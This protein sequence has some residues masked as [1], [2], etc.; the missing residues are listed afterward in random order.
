MVLRFLDRLKQIPSGDVDSSV[1][2]DVECLIVRSAQYECFAKEIEDLSKGKHLTSS[3]SLYRLDPFLDKVG[4]LRLEGRFENS[5]EPC[6]IKH[7]I[8][9]PKKSCITDMLVR[10]FHER[11]NHPGRYMT[12]NLLRQHG[13]WL[14]NGS[15]VVSKVIRHCVVCRKMRRPSEVHK[16]AGLPADR[17]NTEAPFPYVGCDEFGVYHIKKRRFVLKRYWVLFTCM[18]SR[19]VHLESLNAMTIDSFINALR[20]F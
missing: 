20:R 8:L 18:S 6:E 13:Y 16:M 2:R 1:L 9:S 15:S 5:D 17:F 11:N 19:A 3:S 14:V 10:Y 7:P 12:L 4:V